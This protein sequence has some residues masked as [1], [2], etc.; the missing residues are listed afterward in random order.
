[1][2]YPDWDRFVASTT[3]LL[4]RFVKGHSASM[5]GH[6]IIDVQCDKL[7]KQRLFEYCV[8]N[9][10]AAKEIRDKWSS[11][12]RSM[13]KC[14]LIF[15]DNSV[16]TVYIRAKTLP[17]NQLF[18]PIKR[19]VAIN[20]EKELIGYF[21]Q[22]SYC[23]YPNSEAADR[24]GYF[25]YDFHADSMGDGGLGAHSYFHFH[26][27]LDESYRHATG[28]VLDVGDVVSGIE[29]VL[30]PK[31]RLRRLKQVFNSG[32]FDALLMDLTV[33]GVEDF[34]KTHFAETQSQWNRFKHKAR[35]EAFEKRFLL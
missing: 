32:D 2:L 1:M 20:G 34:R 18:E 33:E 24:I 28:P 8:P 26:R 10:R 17:F 13:P 12:R 19:H 7:T 6:E 22:Y 11:D 27:R 3:V 21:D 9:K 30:S 15:P 31:E 14:G 25:R 16:L 35:Y 29:S 4:D 5:G 23:F